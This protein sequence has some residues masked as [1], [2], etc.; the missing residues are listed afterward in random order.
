VRFGRRPGLRSSRFGPRR[1]PA[2][3]LVAVRMVCAVAQG[4][5]PTL[6]ARRSLTALLRAF[7]RSAFSP[8]PRAKG[9]TEA[10]AITQLGGAEINDRIAEFWA[11][12]NTAC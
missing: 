8:P 6:A 9:R 12:V 11:A 1:L 10:D 4:F 3:T 5:R 2:R 7:L